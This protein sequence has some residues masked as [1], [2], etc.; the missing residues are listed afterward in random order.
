MTTQIPSLKSSLLQTISFPIIRNRGKIEKAYCHLLFMDFN[1]NLIVFVLKTLNLEELEKWEFPQI[2]DYLIRKFEEKKLIDIEKD[3]LLKKDHCEYRI[4]TY[5]EVDFKNEYMVGSLE[6]YDDSCPICLRKNSRF[7][8]LPRCNHKFCEHCLYIYLK[9]SIENKGLTLNHISCPQDRC[10]NILDNIF[11][12]YLLDN[13][14]KLIQK[15]NSYIKRNEALH[16][17]S[18][19]ECI[20]PYC[21]EVLTKPTYGLKIDCLC[22]ESFCLSCRNEWHKNQECIDFAEESHFNRQLAKDNR[23]CPLCK[24]LVEKNEHRIKK[25]CEYCHFEFCWICTIE[26]DRK[27]DV[28]PNKCSKFSETPI[29]KMSDINLNRLENE[30]CEFDKNFL[31]I[32][33][34]FFFQAIPFFIIPYVIFLRS[35]LIYCLYL[36]WASALYSIFYIGRK[37]IQICLPNRW[38]AFF[39]ILPICLASLS[40]CP[41]IIIMNIIQMISSFYIQMAIWLIC[42]KR[43]KDVF[44]FFQLNYKSMMP[45]F[46]NIHGYKNNVKRLKKGWWMAGLL[47]TIIF[48]GWPIVLAEIDF[49]E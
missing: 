36:I 3:F 16:K 39:F 43:K 18:K 19:I 23:I 38:H 25:R 33:F 48:L 9:M 8:D 46:L 20:N 24:E 26:W 47:F 28:C 5:S 14:T 27:N 12:E 7:I 2:I 13:D 34:D 32:F 35:F 41:F 1:K 15:Y 17:F 6:I 42:I 10:L 30:N 31:I 4:S 11:I 29:N 40:V 21:D 22:G 49:S 45:I 44:Y 37:M